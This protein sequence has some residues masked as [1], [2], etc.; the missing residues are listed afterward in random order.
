MSPNT[1]NIIHN[2]LQLPPDIR[3]F[4]AEKLLESL[5][6]EEPFELSQEWKAEIERR[7]QDIDNGTVQL[8]PGDQVIKEAIARLER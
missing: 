5:D 4:I 8:I 6:Y 7:C 1:E 3:A 2:A